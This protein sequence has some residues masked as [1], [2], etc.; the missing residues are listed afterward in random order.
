MMNPVG[1]E[2][3][4][5]NHQ[6]G[7]ELKHIPVIKGDLEQNLFRSAYGSIRR[8]DLTVDPEMP[9]AVSFKKALEHARAGNSNFSPV[10]DKDFFQG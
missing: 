9:A 4:E 1:G 5:V 2:S 3:A 7:G 6:V 8:H 10:Y